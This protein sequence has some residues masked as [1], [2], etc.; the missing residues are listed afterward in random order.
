MKQPLNEA[1][2]NEILKAYQKISD[3][4]DDFTQL[5]RS[6]VPYESWPKHCQIAGINHEL[7]GL[8]DPSGAHIQQMLDKPPIP[9]PNPEYNDPTS[10]QLDCRSDY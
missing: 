3:T 7:L 1:Y 5:M 6:R 4:F 2:Q 10:N 9:M 8:A